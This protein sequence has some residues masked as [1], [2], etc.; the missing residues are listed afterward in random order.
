MPWQDVLDFWTFPQSVVNAIPLDDLHPAD[1]QLV[2]VGG[3][4]YV[5]TAGAWRHIPDIP[6]FQ[7]RGY[8]WC[9]ITS[10]D[11]NFL[12]RVRVGRPLQSSGTAE[13]ANYPN[14]RE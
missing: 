5:F 12:S 14:C 2:D 11:A 8:F 4:F 1:E 13:I 3:M 9:D 6:T 7:A 10:A